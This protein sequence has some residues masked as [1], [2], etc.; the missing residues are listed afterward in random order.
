MTSAGKTD[1]EVTDSSSDHAEKK[2]RNPISDKGVKTKKASLA[3]RVAALENKASDT[4][5]SGE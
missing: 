2:R 5:M 3:A 4:I 1:G